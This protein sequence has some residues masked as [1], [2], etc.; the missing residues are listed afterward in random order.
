[1]G[2]VA[3]E[4]ARFAAHRLDRLGDPERAARM[5]AYLKTDMPHFGVAAPA[6]RAL[7]REM[8]ERFP[9]SSRSGYTRGVET[10]W[11]GAHREEKYLAIGLARGYPR[12]QT[13]G[14]LPLYR[15][16]IVTGAWWDLVDEVAIH[17]VGSVWRS[18]RVRT[19]PVMERW[20]DA[21]E[22]WLRRSA[23]IGQ[24]AH[25]AETDERLLFE[26][27]LRRAHEREFFI[28]KAIGWALRSYARTAPE[29]VAAFVD[30]HRDAWSGLTYREAMK[31]LQ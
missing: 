13:I 2:E 14:S 15:R 7:A 20:I 12:Y 29:A 8:I 9:V 28:R 16:M 22:L 25:R 3:A 17:L 6:R 19:T 4:R 5:A 18:D 26:F 11:A 31:H 30:A 10:L 24:I 1:M 21:P 23:L 27:C